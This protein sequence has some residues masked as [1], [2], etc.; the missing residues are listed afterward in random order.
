MIK[1]S[2]A[3]KRFGQTVG[4]HVS[5]RDIL[6]RDSVIVDNIAE[7]RVPNVDMFSPVMK[8]IVDSER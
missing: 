4:Q 3:G 7:E 6:N 2:I 1:L 5:S 8:N